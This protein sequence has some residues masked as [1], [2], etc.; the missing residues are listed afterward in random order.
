MIVSLIFAI[1]S[2]PV[3]VEIVP[4]VPLKGSCRGELRAVSGAREVATSIDGAR[5]AVDLDPGDWTLIVDSQECWSA[6][7]AV[8]IAPEV[9]QNAVRVPV[10]KR[11]DFSGPLKVRSSELPK[12]VRV[13]VRPNGT[14]ASRTQTCPVTDGI[15]RCAGPRAPSDLRVQADGFAPVY[16]WGAG[17]TEAITTLPAATLESGGSVIGWVVAPNGTP[18]AD[19]E[20]NV[21]ADT[22]AGRAPVQFATTAASART[23]ARGFFQVRGLPPGSYN[24]SARTA[25]KDASLVYSVDATEAREYVVPEMALEP[26]ATV[27]VSIEPARTPDGSRWLVALERMTRD[28]IVR[29]EPTPSSEE[30]RWQGD[31]VERGPY[32]LR[33]LDGRGSVV[34]RA[35]LQVDRDLVPLQIVIGQVPVEGRVRSAAGEP[36]KAELRFE[37]A[38]GRVEIRSDEEGR[39]TGWLP[40][41]GKWGVQVSP[42]GELIRIRVSTDV[43]VSPT[44]ST[45][46]VDI[47]LPDGEIRGRVEDRQG[48]PV[49]SA[50]VFA[51]RG[52]DVLGSL[53]TKADGTFVLYG[54]TT[55]DVMLDA[56]TRTQE[57]GKVRNTVSRGTGPEVVLIVGPPERLT[58]K[59]RHANGT[60]VA[61]ALV[62]AL[63]RNLVRSDVSGPNGK[64][65]LRLPPGSGFADVAVLAPGLPIKIVRVAADAERLDL[66]MSDRAGILRIRL[67]RDSDGWPSLS[68]DG[69]TLSLPLLLMPAEGF[70]I[71]EADGDA[72]R[73]AVEPGTYSVCYRGSAPSCTSHSVAAGSVVEVGGD[74]DSQG[75]VAR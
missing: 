2:L 52:A 48:K 44:A 33:V 15:W 22:F 28:G 24:V 30:G 46:T 45:A 49:A 26:A 67:R 75:G 5:F 29:G 54:L 38:H 58:G 63:A 74:N 27:D 57:S 71:Q 56:K 21:A 36:L 3:P 42:E 65:E 47:D 1:A 6:S 59:V 17:G 39:F 13:E 16:F 61:G 72:V 37:S 41:E 50:A 18:A 10:W 64:F 12:E 62:R 31:G 43:R 14:T 55:G 7:V 9:T 34:H 8:K 53:S 11:A 60:P 25:A 32:R 23:N 51:M 68:K 40:A 4:A 35:E 69:A 20:V 70:G 19:A 66:L 73:I